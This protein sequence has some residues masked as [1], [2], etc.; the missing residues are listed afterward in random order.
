MQDNPTIFWFRND[1]RIHDLPA[2]SAAAAAGQP[3]LACYILDDEN[4]GS[5]RMGEASRWW[6]HRSLSKLAHDVE[7]LGGLLYLA[8]GRPE[9]VLADFAQAVSA[10]SVYCSRQYAPWSSSLESRVSTFL[11]R[12]NV[13]LHRLTGSLLWEPQQVMTRAGTPFKVFT[14]F[15]KACKALPE[16]ALP[17]GRPSLQFCKSS[18]LVGENLSDLNLIPDAQQ[19]PRGWEENWQP[20]EQG[21]K[22]R[23]KTFSRRYPGPLH[24]GQGPARP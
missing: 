22:V 15:W 14:P 4:P 9:T 11:G 23:L 18:A 13:D 3:I 12:Y 7:R 10:K 1:L 21:G 8:R 19:Q 20:G 6:L 24:R 17:S 16:P 5:W 2:L